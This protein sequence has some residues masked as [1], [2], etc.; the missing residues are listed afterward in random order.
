MNKREYIEEQLAELNENALFMD[1]HDDAIIG[2]TGTTEPVVVYS[3]QAIIDGLITEMVSEGTP[4]E[5]A[6]E[7]AWDHYGF[8]ILGSLVGDRENYPI[9]IRTI[10][11]S[12]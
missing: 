5:Q 7:D 10:D 11:E 4:Y 8:N 6:E 12:V 2:V 9:I 1:G 3:E